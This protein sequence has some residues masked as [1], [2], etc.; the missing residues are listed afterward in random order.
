VD[1]AATGDSTKPTIR[2]FI[3]LETQFDDL[4][5]QQLA[6]VEAA[7]GYDDDEAASISQ[8]IDQ[9]VAEIR[10]FCS[11]LPFHEISRAKPEVFSEW[12]AQKLLRRERSNADASEYVN[13]RNL[14][15][16]HLVEVD[17][18][19]WRKR[20]EATDRDR[21]Q[22]T[23]VRN[24]KLAVLYLREFEKDPSK[25]TTSLMKEVGAMTQGKDD[26][27]LILKRSRSN[28]AIPKGLRGL[29]VES[30]EWQDCK[31]FI[32]RNRAVLKAR[33]ADRISFEDMINQ[34]R[35]Q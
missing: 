4:R 21:R 23:A 24:M 29:G 26:R 30:E 8:K 2:R 33:W 22:G 5:R 35:R 1:I 14:I 12:Y 9:V 15:L 3:E 7:N 10:Q 28:T 25:A 11:R 31:P 6:A 27:R 20:R 32:E 19:E 18:E 17:D 16:V 34:L 13:I